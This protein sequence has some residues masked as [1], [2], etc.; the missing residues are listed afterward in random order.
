[1][2]IGIAVEQLKKHVQF[3]I[4]VMSIDCLL[5]FNVTGRVIVQIDKGQ[6]FDGKINL[7]S[8]FYP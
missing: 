6:N 5:I 7:Y 8:I 1:M 2:Q 3:T 4:Y